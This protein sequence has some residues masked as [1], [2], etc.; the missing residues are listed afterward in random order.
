[1]GPQEELAGQRR[2]VPLYSV[3][4]LR[5]AFALGGAARQSEMLHFEVMRRCSERLVAR[6][7]TG[8]GWD[9]ALQAELRHAGSHPPPPV[10]AGSKAPA[11]APKSPSLMQTLQASG[12]DDRKEFLQGA[13]QGRGNPIWDL[14]N[15]DRPKPPWTG[16]TSWPQPSVVSC[17]A[18]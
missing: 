8:A 7:F 16:S 5:V 15:R 17:T 13:I 3:C 6:P 12:F 10:D 18:R 9:P 4:A 1:M 2:I 11:P 14:I